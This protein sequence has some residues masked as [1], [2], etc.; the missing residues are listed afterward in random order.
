MAIFAFFS[1]RKEEEIL[2]NK[3]EDGTYTGISFIRKKI[4][5]NQP[6]FTNEQIIFYDTSQLSLIINNKKYSHKI[7]GNL[8]S[9]SLGTGTYEL[10]KDSI[11]FIREDIIAPSKVY[12][13]LFYEIRNTDIYFEYDMLKNANTFNSLFGLNYPQ[14][15]NSPMGYYTITTNSSIGS[16]CIKDSCI[17]FIKIDAFINKK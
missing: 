4:I 2:T 12:Y 10:L 11:K 3:L 1:C 7:T 16:N 15:V 9:F 5:V 6:V 8:S 17:V 14:T 13:T